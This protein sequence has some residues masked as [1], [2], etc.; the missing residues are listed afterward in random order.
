M[1]VAVLIG[2]AAVTLLTESA[3]SHFLHGLIA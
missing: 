3:A 2:V 1:A